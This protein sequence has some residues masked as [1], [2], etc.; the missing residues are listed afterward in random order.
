MDFDNIV[1][2]YDEDGNEIEFEIIE[3]VKFR[4]KEYF[5]LWGEDEDEERV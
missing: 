4:G 5:L 1:T 2:L 3:Q